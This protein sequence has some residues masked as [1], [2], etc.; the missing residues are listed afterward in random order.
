M[1]RTLSFR[2]DEALASALDREADR[3]CAA[4]SDLLNR[5]V[6]EFL[7]RAECERDADRYDELSL[8]PSEAGNQHETGWLGDAPDTDWDQVFGT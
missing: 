7:Y 1:T 5:A 8:T 6:R 2:A 4:R 3:Q